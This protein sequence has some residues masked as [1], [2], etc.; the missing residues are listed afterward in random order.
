MKEFLFSQI[1]LT[2]FGTLSQ[3]LP[4]YLIPSFF[5]L[6]TRQEHYMKYLATKHANYFRIRAAS[7]FAHCA[8]QYFN[9]LR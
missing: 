6:V 3:V 9:Q 2:A 7:L 1:L 5:I 8:D 4:S